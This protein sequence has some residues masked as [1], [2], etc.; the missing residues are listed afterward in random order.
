[1][2]I[3]PLLLFL[4]FL[5]QC[6]SQQAHKNTFSYQD[7]ADENILILGD[8]I[9]QNGRYVS[10]VDYYLQ[11]QKPQLNYSLLSIGLSSETA[12]GISEPHHPFPRPCIHSRLEQ[13]LI[14]I[15]PTILMACY[16]MNDGIYHPL[17]DEILTQYKVGIN[18]LV[19]TARAHG[20]KHIVLNSPPYFDKVIVSKK[21][22][23]LGYNDYGFKTPYENYNESLIAFGDY[24]AELAKGNNDIS[25]IDLNAPMATYTVE[26]NTHLN[27][28]GVH[29][30]HF[31]HFLMAT[32][33]ANQLGINLKKDSMD[34]Q[35]KFIENSPLFK[36]INK[37]RSLES[38][39]WLDYIGYTR[40]NKS[41]K[42]ESI[43]QA[44]KQVQQLKDQI[45]AL[46]K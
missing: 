8:S 34:S 33:I 41:I 23:P 46:S 2:K 39:A 5:T 14:K 15:Q 18:K 22:K 36:L 17:N 20:V 27:K 30:N 31:G 24:L 10:Y 37:L 43:D 45:D 3:A 6:T 7:L 35:F 9:T 26:H 19:A 44:T 40:G 29:P 12:S 21:T 38:K 16:G 1:M 13:A 4:V 42:T 28:D 32:T 25:Y 11:A